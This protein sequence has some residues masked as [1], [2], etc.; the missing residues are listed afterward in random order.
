MEMF[1]FDCLVEVESRDK[2]VV[3][4]LVFLLCILTRSVGSSTGSV[5]LRSTICL[6]SFCTFGLRNGE[7]VGWELQPA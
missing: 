6:I 5:I 3:F 2:F 7:F 4:C 1:L